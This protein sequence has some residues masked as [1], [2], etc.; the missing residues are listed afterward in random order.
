VTFQL[1]RARDISTL[2]Q[3]LATRRVISNQWLRDYDSHADDNFTALNRSPT[4]PGR[5]HG[6]TGAGFLDRWA[7]WSR[8]R[9]MFLLF[10]LDSGC[11]ES[12]REDENA[13]GSRQC[14]LMILVSIGALVRSDRRRGC[15]TGCRIA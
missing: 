7:A 12:L 11:R 9:P 6:F 14:R 8:L 15:S 1:C 3:H 2:L 5:L 10:L 4:G 13:L